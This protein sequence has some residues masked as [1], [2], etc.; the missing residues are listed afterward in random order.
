MHRYYKSPI[1]EEFRQLVN[2]GV[3]QVGGIRAEDVQA[4]A[5]FLGVSVRTVQRWFTTAGQRRD[6]IPRRVVGQHLRE[7]SAH[8]ASR[9]LLGA[10]LMG[11][12]TRCAGECKQCKVWE[13][14]W[15]NLLGVL[16]YAWALREGMIDPFLVCVWRVHTGVAWAEGGEQIGWKSV[17]EYEASEEQRQ[18]VSRKLRGQE[19]EPGEEDDILP[20][21]EEPCEQDD[22]AYWRGV[23][24]DLGDEQGG[25]PS[26]D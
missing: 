7:L 11:E 16:E 15:H 23:W 20:F 14:H 22:F 21:D 26:R 2:E 17:I 13:E 6:L 24:G 25:C 1:S 8:D 5:G 18:R 19:E 12:H 9:V 10:A 3:R 4:L